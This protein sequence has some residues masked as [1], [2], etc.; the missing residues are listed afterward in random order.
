MQT[1]S[2]S[3]GIHMQAVL[4]PE[5]LIFLFLGSNSNWGETRG[6]AVWKRNQKTMCQFP[7]TKRLPFIFHGVLSNKLDDSEK[8]ISCDLLLRGI[9]P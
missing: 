8:Y 1:V 3:A 6:V 9:Y 4:A 2:G 7:F 5:A